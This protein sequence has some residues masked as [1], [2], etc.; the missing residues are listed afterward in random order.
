MLK[1]T[2]TMS[3]EFQGENIT[4]SYTFEVGKRFSQ[5]Y[6]VQSFQEFYPQYANVEVISYEEVERELALQAA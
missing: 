6:L 3:A 1:F 5:E 2:L 4:H